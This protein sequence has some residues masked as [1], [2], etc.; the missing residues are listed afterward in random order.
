MSKVYEI[1]DEYVLAYTA[2]DPV[3]ATDAGVAGHDHELTNYSPEASDARA[4]L[5]RETL[6][7]LERAPR[8]DDRDRIAADVMAERLSLAVELHDAGEDLRALRI[9]GSP[10]QDIRACFD[11]MAYDTEHD[12]EVAAQRLARVPESLASFEAALRAGI[13]RGIVAARRQVLGCAGQAGAWGGENAGSPPFFVALIA[14]HGGDATLHAELERLAR[15]ATE[16]Y[17]RHAAFLRDEYAPKSDPRD[18]VGRD[19]YAL[20]ARSF[21]GIDLDLDETYA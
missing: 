14:G 7:A 9:I 11:L 6:T 5:D 20:F 19:R 21:N 15:E 2:L 8:N 4:Q 10:V 12:W 18:P 3:A 16:A 13:E 17:A 1:A